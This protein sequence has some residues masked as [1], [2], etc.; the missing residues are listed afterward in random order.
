MRKMRTNRISRKGRKSCFLMVK[1]IIQ[2][3]SFLT[4]LKTRNKKSLS[5]KN[6]ENG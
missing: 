6:K 1:D 5:R 3:R 2:K 4:H